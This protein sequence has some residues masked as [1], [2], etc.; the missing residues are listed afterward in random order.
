MNR[1]ALLIPALCSG[2]DEA[3]IRQALSVA[4]Q[5]SLVGWDKENIPYTIRRKRQEFFDNKSQ[6]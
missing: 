6:K 3:V 1:S 4:S 2:R 5:A